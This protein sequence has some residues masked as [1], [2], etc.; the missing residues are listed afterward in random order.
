MRD[1][2]APAWRARN[3]PPWPSPRPSD[4]HG[5]AG[6]RGHH[7]RLGRSHR[8]QQDG[9]QGKQP[10]PSPQVERD[11]LASSRSADIVSARPALATAARAGP[12][13]PAGR[14]YPASQLGGGGISTSGAAA[15][16]KST[17]SASP[18]GGLVLR[19]GPAGP[20]REPGQP[21]AASWAGG[22]RAA[23]GVP[24][25]PASD[26]PFLRTFAA[27][28]RTGGG[29]GASFAAGRCLR[30]GA[31]SEMVRPFSPSSAKKPG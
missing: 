27:L 23:N 24:A 9:H 25:L 17:G 31:C 21:V 14:D 5:R 12:S 26:E 11:G 20:G 10:P 19:A 1:G 18:P 6:D 8:K 22:N 7:A 4:W 13:A 15:D 28:H 16:G 30:A 29:A 2:P 3:R